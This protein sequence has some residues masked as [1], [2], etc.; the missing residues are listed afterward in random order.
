MNLKKFRSCQNIISS[1]I[2][3]IVLCFFCYTTEFKLTEIQLSRWSANNEYSWLWNLSIIMLSFSF[4]F[5]Y[6]NF[7]NS[8]QKI[9]KK[10]TID[11]LF[12]ITTGCLFLTGVFN[13]SFLMLHNFFA[14]VYFLAAPVAIF[15]FAHFNAAQLP[16]R[17]WKTHLT[18]S[19]LSVVAPIITLFFFNGMAISEIIHT[20]FIMVWN[21]LAMKN[22]LS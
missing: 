5:N 4:F 21:M 17:V 14:W 18:I 22:R 20:S 13:T 6:K 9:E 19:L 12:A 15:A 10:F 1:T 16:V 3:L 2:F 7:I 11:V 8:Y